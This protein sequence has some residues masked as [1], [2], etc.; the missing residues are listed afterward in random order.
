[1]SG[2]DQRLRALPRFGQAAFDH[3][4]VEALLLRFA[5]R[6]HRFSEAAQA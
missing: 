6:G 2:Q 1:M 5:G 3:E 4:H